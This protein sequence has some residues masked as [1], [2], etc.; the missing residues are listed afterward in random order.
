[1][2]LE[3]LY[4]LAQI[5]AALA[6]V[7]SLIFVGLQVRAQTEEQAARRL[8]ERVALT[9]ALTRLTIE[10]PD[11]RRVIAIANTGIEKLSEDDLPIFTSFMR[12][13]FLLTQ[14][15]YSSTPTGQHPDRSAVATLT[16]VLLMPGALQF[17]KVFQTDYSTDFVEFTNRLIEWGKQEGLDERPYWSL[18]KLEE[19]S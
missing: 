19:Q 17:W 11:V 4:F 14:V 2:S 10:E 18:Q 5:V 15:V 9:L 13:V 12:Q 8:Q 1:M 6:I 16:R 7:A 3:A